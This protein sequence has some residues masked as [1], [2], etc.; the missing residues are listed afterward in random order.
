MNTSRRNA[1][2]VAQADVPTPKL[3]AGAIQAQANG[4]VAPRSDAHTPLFLASDRSPVLAQA[5]FAT[6]P[7][8]GVRTTPGRSE[9]RAVLA[10]RSDMVLLGGPVTRKG[11]KVAIDKVTA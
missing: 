2:A 11:T 8:Q 6:L 5:L 10:V 4:R 1:R 3:A 7:A 9:A